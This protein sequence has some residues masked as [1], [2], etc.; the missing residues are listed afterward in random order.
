MGE[1]THPEVYIHCF[2]LLLWNT[3]GLQLQDIS[4]YFFKH[5][6]WTIV[7]NKLKMVN[8]LTF[9][10][11]EPQGNDE[12]STLPE[13]TGTGTM[14]LWWS[15]FFFFWL[16]YIF[17]ILWWGLLFTGS[18][19]WKPFWCSISINILKCSLSWYPTH[20]YRSIKICPQSAKLHQVT[21]QCTATCIVNQMEEKLT[22]QMAPLPQVS[23]R[24]ILKPQW[25]YRQQVER[26]PEQQCCPPLNNTYI[27][28]YHES[29]GL[30]RICTHK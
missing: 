14:E 24:R 11:K 20:W 21:T 22:H 17:L 2:I 10:P 8:F 29:T 5:F 25:P 6:K 23:D 3:A 9:N 12:I 18:V 27:L 19:I 4:V 7:P 16:C 26:R 30:T 1:G 13:R 15:F 28:E